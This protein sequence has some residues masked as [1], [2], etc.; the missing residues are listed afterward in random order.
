MSNYPQ[1]GLPQRGAFPKLLA[2]RGTI[3]TIPNKKPRIALTGMKF[4]DRAS[5][6]SVVNI[7][8]F[9]RP[10]S[11]VLWWLCFMLAVYVWYVLVR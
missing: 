7:C 1:K 5:L 3:L 4:R 6:K 11:A 8:I 10:R 9:R 2:E